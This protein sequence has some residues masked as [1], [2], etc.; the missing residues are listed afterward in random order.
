MTIRRN[1]VS[2]LPPEVESLCIGKDPLRPNDC[3]DRTVVV[4]PFLAAVIDGATDL[5]GISY[6]GHKPGWISAEIVARTLKRNA[7]R[8]YN[9][10][11]DD[12][13]MSREIDRSFKAVYDHLDL[14]ET[15][16]HQPSLRFRSGGTIAAAT[17]AGLRI[18]GDL[19]LARVDGVVLK[20]SEPNDAERVFIEMRRAFWQDKAFAGLD[21]AERDKEIKSLLVRGISPP[22]Q[23]ED[24]CNRVTRQLL[25]NPRFSRHVVEEALLHGLAGIRETRDISS[26]LF[27]PAFDGFSSQSGQR[28]V[29]VLP[30]G[31]FKTIELFSDGYPGIPEGTSGVDWENLVV[32]ANQTD[33]HRIGLFGAVKGCV[34]DGHH[35]DRSLVIVRDWK[36]PPC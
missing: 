10:Q 19:S 16:T 7:R 36:E 2:D 28:P 23:H 33:P 9:E 13:R 24:A 32:M 11:W 34:Q 35:D 31:S 8:A 22:S 25:E 30:W 27:S 20:P 21:A 14:T 3:E 18:S 29:T 26:A 12:L 1:K 6:G 4:L 5:F 17:H 15:V